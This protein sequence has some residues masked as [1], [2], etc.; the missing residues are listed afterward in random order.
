MKGYIETHKAKDGTKHYRAG[1]RIGPRITHGV[2]RDK[3]FK[4]TADLRK[5]LHDIDTGQNWPIQRIAFGDL[6][7]KW[8][9]AKIP[10]L[11]PSTRNDYRSTLDRHLI[12]EFGHYK[13]DQISP[14]I[15]EDYIGKLRK[16]GLKPKSIVEILRVLSQS[17]RYA[18][19]RQHIRYNPLSDVQKPRIEKAE[20]HY[21]RVEEI[22]AFLAAVPR[23]WKTSEELQRDFNRRV[24]DLSEELRS[25]VVGY[26]VRNKTVKGVASE[27]G[28]AAGTAKS[29]L[30]TAREILKFF[31]SRSDFHGDYVLFLTAILTGMRE[32]ELLGLQWNDVDWTAKKIR[33]R[34]ALWRGK[35]DGKWQCLLQAPKSKAAIRDIDVGDELL[36][37]LR[38]HKLVSPKSHLD[39]VFCSSDG[40]PL[41]VRTLMRWHFHPALERAGLRRI[42]FHDLRHT[43]ASLL[44]AQGENP[45]YIQRQLGH[46]SIKTT[47]DTYGHLME[48]ANPKA[49]LRLAATV[50]K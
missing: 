21:L 39:L 19:R 8:I 2:W 30:H 31:P 23:D 11:K 7:E 5:A 20:M 47:F 6:A 16:T 35:L 45:K 42:R 49:A 3:R 22:H 13:I 1:W 15:L 44:I 29:R 41:E 46:A 27:L 38:K 17:F 28:I 24:A 9:A 12:P 18:V 34:R 14:A 32:G 36:Q 26:Y 4:A 48:E 50:L 33:V 25:V 10:D 43:Y 37:E 40:K